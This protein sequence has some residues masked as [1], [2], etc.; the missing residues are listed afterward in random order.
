LP[1]FFIMNI[2]YLKIL[3]IGKNIDKV[4]LLSSELYIYIIRIYTTSLSHKAV[5]R[6]VK[7]FFLIV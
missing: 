2:T 4:H 5:T 3:K 7:T 1:T 6:G